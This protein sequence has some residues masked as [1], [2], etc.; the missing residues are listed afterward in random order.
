M[1]LFLFVGVYESVPRCDSQHD[2]IYALVLYYTCN[3]MYLVQAVYS[4]HS[5]TPDKRQ[6]GASIYVEWKDGWL[7]I[8]ARCQAHYVRKH[9][10]QT[11]TVVRYATNDI[12][13]V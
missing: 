10:A 12:L 4:M 5:N 6:A 7:Y 8:V 3:N 9:L 1:I 2:V 13:S 11:T